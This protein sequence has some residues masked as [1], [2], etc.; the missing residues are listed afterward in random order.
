VGRLVSLP[1]RLTGRSAPP[2]PSCDHGTYEKEK[3]MKRPTLIA[4]T[5]PIALVLG[6]ATAFAPTTQAQPPVVPPRQPAPEYDPL[7]GITQAQHNEILNAILRALKGSSAIAGVAPT[8]DGSVALGG[9][10]ETFVDVR[11]DGSYYDPS[12]GRRIAIAD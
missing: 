7:A 10:S 4:K 8:Q 5:V 6:L 12:L 9:T 2:W 11:A 3:K 1:R